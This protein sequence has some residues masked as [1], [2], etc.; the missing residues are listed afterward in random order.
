MYGCNL[1]VTFASIAAVGGLP[2]SAGALCLGVL[3]YQVGKVYGQASRDMR[4]LGESVSV[5]HGMPRV[6]TDLLFS[7]LDSITASPLYSLYAETIAGVS[8][9]RAFGA[10]ANTLRSM[11][12]CVD[13]NLV[14]F[15]WTWSLNRWLSARVNMLSSAVL[16][17]QRWTRR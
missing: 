10:S 6:L 8:V 11:M 2:F 4:R 16:R 12:T 14:A 15:Y 3:Y 9:V 13:S 17:P 7:D 5:D 1:V